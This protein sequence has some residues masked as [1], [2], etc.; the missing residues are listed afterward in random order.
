MKWW[1]FYIRITW[2]PPPS[3]SGMKQCMW[4]P[5]CHAIAIRLTFD[6]NKDTCAIQGPYSIG[7]SSKRMEVSRQ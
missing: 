3:Y 2:N 6:T 5:N 1:K 4:T 7:N